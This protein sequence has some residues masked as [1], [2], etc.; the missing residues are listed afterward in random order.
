M[1]TY[2]NRK[3]S[4]RRSPV[5]K[6]W[7]KT[8]TRREL[9]RAQQARRALPPGLY[10]T[11]GY[12]P[13]PAFPANLLNT[14][15]QYKTRRGQVVSTTGA[16]VQGPSGAVVP[17]L[18]QVG[19]DGHLIYAPAVQQPRRRP[20]E[21]T[22]AG[23]AVARRWSWRNRWQLAP[24]VVAGTTAIGA[25]VT[26]VPTVLGLG[27]LAAGGFV[28]AEKGPDQIAGREW[29]SRAERTIAGRWAASAAVWSAGIGTANGLG[30]VWNG[31]TV[32]LATAALGALVGAPTVAWLRSRRIRG[33]GADKLSAATRQLIEAWPATI[34]VSG[35]KCLQGSHIVTE[36]ASEPS[37][38]TV[39]FLVELRGDVHAE[40]AAGD[41][42][43]KHLERQLRMGLNT[44]V[45]EANREDSGQV[46]ITLAPSRHLEKVAAVWDGPVLRDDGTIPLAVTRDGA[47]IDVGLFGPSGV[48]HAVIF[49]ASDTG[50]SFTVT[51][52]VL[53]GVCT[54]REVLFYIDGGQGTSA[55]HLTG[56]CD[57]YAVQDVVEWCQVIETAHR[58]MKVRKARRAGQSSWRGKA[59]KDPVVTLLVDEATTVLGML[60]GGANGKYAAM[61]L[62]I[63]REGR[64]LGVRCIQVT[65]DSQSDELIGGRK[66]RAQMAGA[67][68]MIGHR[69]ADITAATLAASSTSEKVD[70]RAL[71]PEPGWV[72][73]IRKGKVL[74]HAARVR[75]ATPQQV[76]TAITQM[77]QKGLRG[78]SGEDLAA[79]GPAYRQR[80]HGP[81]AAAGRRGDA[82][83]AAG[84]TGHGN[85]ITDAGPATLPQQ[86]TPQ[87]APD[88]PQS[89]SIA[90]VLNSTAKANAAMADTRRTAVLI[91][92][93]R[94]G[95]D[96]ATAAYLVKRTGI[97]KTPIG[98]YINEL[99]EQGR[100]EKIEGTRPRRVRLSAANE[101]A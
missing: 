56:A 77:L 67:G 73:I 72:G 97:P 3:P 78:L 10:G 33:T 92:I 79:A 27:A 70:L 42:V 30:L 94:A 6:A 88:G 95:A 5:R 25:G 43:R 68:S 66:A 31:S 71:P 60:P 17:L 55:G 34:G 90:A 86:L 24:F 9:R 35:P 50:K 14:A 100:A 12:Q 11:Y 49:G 19:P 58:I 2:R 36:S 93:G 53:P 28:A 7:D 65:Q 62:E 99:I 63:L 21:S 18:P 54:Q 52:F 64:K 26:P 81:A 37:P 51:A 91:E 15:G 82:G 45:V 44:A 46:R 96:G 4:E 59:E 20:G 80:V 41:D 40:D 38:G 39:T 32:G 75:Y 83:N 13:G 84:T 101:V 98:R 23:L 29:L 76:E 8:P 87:P 57:W 16:R 74:A 47:D 48:E 61:V 69:V 89:G 1:S 22:A 85:H